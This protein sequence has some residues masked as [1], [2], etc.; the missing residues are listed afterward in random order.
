MFSAIEGFTEKS[1]MAENLLTVL[2]PFYN[3]ESLAAYFTEVPGITF[4][5][6]RRVARRSTYTGRFLLIY[7]TNKRYEEAPAQWR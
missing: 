6:S 5:S 2:P 3:R 1:S 4:S 7:R